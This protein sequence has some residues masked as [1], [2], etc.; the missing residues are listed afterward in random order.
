MGTRRKDYVR[1]V[2][3]LRAIKLHEPVTGPQL[4]KMFKRTRQAIHMRLKMMERRGLI[5]RVVPEPEAPIVP[6]RYR[7]SFKLRE[8]EQAL[9]KQQAE[10]D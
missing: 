6:V 5:E 1:Q 4:A 3:L 7:C 9:A 2:D 10:T 8:I